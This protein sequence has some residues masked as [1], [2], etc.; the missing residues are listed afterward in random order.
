MA[1][2]RLVRRVALWASGAAVLAAVVWGAFFSPLLALDARQVEISGQGTTVDVAQVQAVIAQ[3]VG[4][5]L[6]RLDTV[7]LR[8]RLLELGGV[9]D[10]RILRAWPHG[11]DVALTAREPAAAVP[12]AEGFALVDTEGVRV[13]SAPEPPAGLPIVEASL[14][15]DGAPALLAALRVLAGLPPDLAGEVTHVS[16]ASRDDVRTTLASGQEVRWGSDDR[17]PLKVAVVQTLR[18]AD[19]GARVYDV[20][21]PDLPVTR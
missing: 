17:V 11:L 12:V 19:P 1:R 6:P 8:D 15:P 16:A 10:A 20:G 14:E 18:Q 21:S 2:H 13:G 7:G 9:K 3:N 5:P 4:V